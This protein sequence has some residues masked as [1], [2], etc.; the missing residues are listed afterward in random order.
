M[1]SM[2]KASSERAERLRKV[3]GMTG[4][5]RKSF[6]KK[7]QIPVATIQNWEAPRFGG[8]SER[9]VRKMIQCL[10]C[11]GVYVTHEWLM[12]GVGN[13]PHIAKVSVAMRSRY[14]EGFHLAA[15]EVDIPKTWYK[16]SIVFQLADDWLPPYFTSGNQFI[17]VAKEKPKDQM[18][19]TGSLCVVTT[20]EDSTIL[21]Y[22]KT[23]SPRQK[24]VILS[25]KA[26]AVTDEQCFY[27]KIHQVVYINFR[28]TRVKK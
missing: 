15:K 22:V 25:P 24:K 10:A 5:T 26:I 11:E 2:V 14:R 4:L 17:G 20:G 23:I 13:G 7:Y 8:L 3:R 27:K 16:K 19:L 1:K 9:G 6:S 18:D 21:G 28:K 12:M